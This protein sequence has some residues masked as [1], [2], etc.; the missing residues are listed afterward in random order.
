MC[1]CLFIYSIYYLPNV[2]SNSQNVYIKRYYLE[3]NF[4]FYQLFNSFQLNM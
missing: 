2:K 3:D 1:G 4:I